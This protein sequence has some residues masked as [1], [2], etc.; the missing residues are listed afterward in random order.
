MGS[1]P[2]VSPSPWEAPGCC[3]CAV[4]S[5][6][7]GDAWAQLVQNL[8]R[9]WPVQHVLHCHAVLFTSHIEQSSRISVSAGRSSSRHNGQ[10]WVGLGEGG[11]GLVAS[12]HLIATPSR[13]S[14][15]RVGVILAL[16]SSHIQSP[17]VPA[18]FRLSCSLLCASLTAASMAPS[19]ATAFPARPST[20]AGLLAWAWGFLTAALAFLA[21]L[22]AVRR[23]TL[24]SGV[25]QLL[26]VGGVLATVPFLLG[27]EPTLCGPLSRPSRTWLPC[28][29]KLALA[30]AGCRDA[31]SSP[32]PRAGPGSRG[33]AAGELLGPRPRISLTPTVSGG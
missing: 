3:C 21:A 23:E 11:P 15:I 14:H 17:G 5:V 4:P 25:N 12:P 22:P 13:R 10:G 29:V 24:P 1:P 31:P 26:P 30:G 7:P 32:R 18:R 16:R 20:A 28:E 33:A 19:G 6:R 8:T 27:R 9:Q 2:G